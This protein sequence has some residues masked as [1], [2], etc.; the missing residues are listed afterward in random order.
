MDLVAWYHLK[1]MEESSLAPL[2]RSITSMI[3]KERFHT[4]FGANRVKAHRRRPGLLRG[5]AGGGAKITAQVVPPGPGHLAVKY[6]VRRRG[7]EELRQMYR[8]D[9]DPFL[10]KLGNEVPDKNFDRH[11]V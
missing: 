7:N 3:H 6:G 2:A 5:R 8:R 9:I 10:A 11:V 1:A 4:S